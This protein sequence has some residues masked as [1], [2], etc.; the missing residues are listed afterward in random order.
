MANLEKPIKPTL[1]EFNLT[2]G[3]VTEL[4]RFKDRCNTKSKNYL[5][6]V[7][8]LLSVVAVLIIYLN[9]LHN[10]LL[11][12]TT[13]CSA[14]I[15][16]GIIPFLIRSITKLQFN[17]LI[18]EKIKTS[19]ISNY[20][21]KNI[22]YS[23]AMTEYKDKNQLF[24]R[25]LRR[26]TW[27]H[28]LSL[29]PIEFE[30][31]VADL[32]IDKGYDVYT[33]PVTGDHGVDLFITKDG[34]TSIVQ[35]KTYKKSLGPSAARD[36]YGAMIAQGAKEAFLAAPGG[37]TVATKEFCKNKPIKLLDIDELTKMSYNY[38][39]YISHWIDSAKS[40]NDIVK[41]INKNILGKPYKKRYR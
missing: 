24:E 32:F 36:L 30:E 1:G 8:G 4:S 2:E 6:L 40:V 35:C 37:F 26:A 14:V 13:I 33:T 5:I 21:E 11:F 16:W 38:E 22:K 25:V 29:N 3:D 18:F 23:S 20:N 10:G 41:G 31:A 12:F 17:D 28:W 39:N 9:G 27:N 19:K 7:F 34:K 15:T